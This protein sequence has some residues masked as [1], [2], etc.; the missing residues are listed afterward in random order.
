MAGF[1]DSAGVKE[2]LTIGLVPILSEEA[3]F[4]VSECGTLRT[5]AFPKL[6]TIPFCGEE[7]FVWNLGLFLLPF[8]E[9]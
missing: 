8:E 1:H 9:V 7:G 2:S 6:Y 3:V 5:S 4:C